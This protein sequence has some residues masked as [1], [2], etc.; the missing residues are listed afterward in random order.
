MAGG[1]HGGHEVRGPVG[2]EKPT[3]E[4]RERAGRG[5]EGAGDGALARQEQRRPRAYLKD[6]PS[7]RPIEISPLSIRRLKP[8]SGLLQTHAL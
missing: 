7:V 3:D 2:L 8:Q 4:S 5:G 1:V 6:W